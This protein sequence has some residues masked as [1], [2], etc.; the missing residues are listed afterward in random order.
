MRFKITIIAF[1]IILP[2]AIF[3]QCKN[4]AKKTCIP[5]LVPFVHN[6]QL[7]SSSLA[8]GETAELSMTFNSGLDYRILVCA[9]DVLGKPTFKVIDVEKNVVYNSAE[10]GA[11]P[12]WDFN[13]E[14]TQQFTVEV[15]VPPSDSPNSIVPTGCVTVLVGFKQ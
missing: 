11:I 1:I 5:K 8:A 6:G 13:V 9:E 2:I 15:S 7:N 3:A 14:S 4:M 10:S 12:F